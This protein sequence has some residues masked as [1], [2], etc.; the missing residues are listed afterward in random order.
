MNRLRGDA[1][2]SARAGAGSPW[3][4][5]VDAAAVAV[6]LLVALGAALQMARDRA[7]VDDTSPLRVRSVPSAALVWRAPLSLEA[8]FA[9]LHWIRAVQH[10]GRTRLSG[11][12]ASDYARLYSLLD[13][14]TTL[15]PRFDAAYRLGAVFLAEPPPGGA[16]RPD[17]AVELLQKGL[18]SEP[19]GWQYLRDIGFIHYWWLRDLDAAA[20]WFQRA[21]DTPG[22]PWWLRFMAAATL[23]EGG[24]RAGARARWRQVRDSAGDPWMRAEAARRLEQLEALDELDHG[25]GFQVPPAG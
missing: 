5:R 25:G 6:V 19:A 2:A 8:V 11:G 15:D 24:D 3:W 4:G 9:D 21:A 10:Y 22:A 1:S 18:A 14:A 13:A 17:L 12:R 20:R 7:T 16:G 23:A